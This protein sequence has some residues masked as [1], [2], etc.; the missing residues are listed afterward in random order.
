MNRIDPEKL[1][2]DNLKVFHTV[3]YTG[4][5]GEAG[6]ILNLS[7]PTVSKQISELEKEVGVKLIERTRGSRSTPVTPYGQIFLELTS[8]FYL[9]LK[10]S[11][12]TL[13]DSERI[14]GEIKIATAKGFG[15]SWLFPKLLDFKIQYP[16]I[17][18]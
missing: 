14:A 13:E 18:F 9:L 4:H 17:T 16:H 6:R 2:W 15:I 7:Q 1:N 3:A 8:N 10:E 12:E 11:I 5:F